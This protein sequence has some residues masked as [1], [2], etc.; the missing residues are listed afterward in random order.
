[1]IELKGKYNRDCKI[2]TDN[3]EDSAYSLIQNILDEKATRGVPVRI[4]PDVHTGV[5]IVIGFTCPMTNY[6]NPDWVGCDIG[7]FTGD[8]LVRVSCKDKSF[9]KFEEL[10]EK[11]KLGDELYTCSY[12]NGEVI[13]TRISNCWITKYVKEVRCIELET[14]YIIKC[15]EDHLFLLTNGTYKEAKY[16]ST[17]DKLQANCIRYNSDESNYILIKNNEIEIYDTE[18]PVYDLEVDHE[19]HNFMISPAQIFVHNCGVE[20]HR[21]NLE[22]RSNELNLQ[23]IDNQI[24]NT[25]PMGDKLRDKSVLDEKEFLKKLKKNINSFHSKYTEHTGINYNLPTINE[26][27]LASTLKRYHMEPQVFYKSI[28][29]L[30]GGNHF[31]EIG[32][33]NS[34]FYWLT[35]HSGSR[36][37]GIRVWKYH[38]N[39]AKLQKD[40]NDPEYSI[41]LEKLKNSVEDRTKLPRLIEELRDKMEVG[42]NK[43]FLRGEFM[44]N[45][46]IDMIF[47]QTY[48]EFN[49]EAMKLEICKKLNC[50][51][52][53][54]VKSIHNYIDFDDFTIRKGSI[55]SYEGERL[56]IPFSM[57]DGL[58]IGEGKSNKDWNNSAPHGAGRV[59]ARGKAKSQLSMDE[60]TEQMKGIYSTSVVPETLDESP[61]AYKDPEL[62]ESLIDP[63]V[64][65]LNKIKPILNIKSID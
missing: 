64:K 61:M 18:I 29:T 26:K 27:W 22:C 9:I 2:F 1:M 41:E 39:Q 53:D 35:I 12:H 55:R 45:Y 28:G 30:G 60:F 4:M 16:L 24:R 3:I 38:T 5:G 8:T 6:I 15:T 14:G 48:A 52:I 44:F 25:I 13:P 46:L 59:L 34:G 32:M 65:V 10:Y 40:N 21:I 54:S 7:C 43:K 56:V 20:T 17:E 42:I 57:K 63:T 49:R 11:F 36:N 47:A 19:C 58:I 50:V 62:I 51:V 33:D 23:L 31:I 37:L